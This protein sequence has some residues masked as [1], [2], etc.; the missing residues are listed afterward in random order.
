M[1]AAVER[2]LAEETGL[3][4]R[5]GAL[6]GWVERIG[7]KHHFVIA[8]FVVTVDRSS[9]AVAASDASAVA[10]VTIDEL[11]AVDLVEGL[12]DFLREHRVVPQA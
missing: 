7:P 10:W 12:L 5:C 6:V 4:G 2:E 8:D 3:T 11:P 1:A 9:A